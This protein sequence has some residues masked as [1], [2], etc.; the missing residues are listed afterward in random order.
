MR[1][2]LRAWEKRFIGPVRLGWLDY[3]R[4]PNRRSRW[5]G[6]LNGQ[7][8][9]RELFEELLAEFEPD[10]VV[11][12]GTYR[13][14]ATAWFA[15]RLSPRPVRSVE[16]DVRTYGF[17]RRALKGLDNVRLALGDSRAHLRDLLARPRL[18]QGLEFFHLDA[19]GSGDSP[20][21]G[22]VEV[23]FSAVPRA[24]VATDDFR[25]PGDPG[26]G[27]DEYEPGVRLGADLLQ[28]AIARYSLA[29]FYPAR[30]SGAEDGARRG[31]GL[32]AGA[33]DIVERLASLEFLRQ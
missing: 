11:E 13:G 22:E 5:G 24:L 7:T 8:D 3:Y 32:L 21:I 9:R 23:V 17:A 33:S 16:A 15:S 28:G 4:F 1:S 19:D 29:L 14:N 2:A 20:L 6:P 31:L 18:R 10:F 25:V 26:Y 27:L 30:P 12:T